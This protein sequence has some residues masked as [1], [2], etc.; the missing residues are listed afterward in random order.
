MP[1]I[2]TS[3]YTVLTHGSVR[4]NYTNIDI[5]KNNFKDTLTDGLLYVIL[6]FILCISEILASFLRLLYMSGMLNH[7]IVESLNKKIAN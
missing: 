6:D 1:V 2:F 3:E 5:L 7:L 4:V